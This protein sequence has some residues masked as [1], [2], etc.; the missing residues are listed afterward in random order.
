MCGIV[1]YVNMGKPHSKIEAIMTDLLVID[2]VRGY[3]STGIFMSG[4]D[5]ENVRRSVLHKKQGTGAEFVV[6]EEWRR[7]RTLLPISD[8]MVGHN[9][10]ATVG[11]VTEENAHPFQ[12]Q[13]IMMVHNG[14]L[15][16]HAKLAEGDFAVDSEYLCNYLAKDKTAQ[17]IRD[18]VNGAYAI[19]WRDAKKNTINFF[20]NYQRPLVF[21]HCEGMLLFAS[22]QYMLEFVASRHKIKVDKYEDLK[23]Y[24]HVEINLGTKEVTTTETKSN[25]IPVTNTGTPGTRNGTSTG[26]KWHP[27]VRPPQPYKGDVINGTPASAIADL[28]VGERLTFMYMDHI[29]EATQDIGLILE[30]SLYQQ[31]PE[32]NTAVVYGTISREILSNVLDRKLAISAVISEVV[33]YQDTIMV[34]VE[35]VTSS[36]YSD[37]EFMHL[38]RKS[39]YAH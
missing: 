33:T 36:C 7:L 31:H 27:C 14:T 37:P 18:D 12:A 5:K 6:A 20:R 2:S 17:D 4:T 23:A 34:N 29:G 26:S 11:H 1:G 24:E 19:V 3:D 30:G 13:H 22:E 28:K 35:N 10:W 8:V 25:F 38:E 9:R 15:H 21:A 32:Y 39:Q 16:G